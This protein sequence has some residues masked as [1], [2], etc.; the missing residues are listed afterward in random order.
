MHA[1]GSA[2]GV[3]F[4]APYWPVSEA[5]HAEWFSEVQRKKDTVGIRVVDTGKLIDSCQ[6][7]GIGP[8]HPAAEL[9]VSLGEEGE[10]RRGYGSEAL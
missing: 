7:H 9:R 5:E 6:L 1:Q 2:R 4:N 8:V 3:D 10:R